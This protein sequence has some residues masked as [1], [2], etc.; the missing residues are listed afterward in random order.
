MKKRWILF[1]V[2]ITLCLS[3]IFPVYGENDDQLEQ[4]IIDSC[5]YNESADLTAYQLTAPQLKEI[6]FRLQNSGQLP[7]YVSD[8]YSYE[9]TS[10]GRITTFTPVQ[11]DKTKY[12]YALYEQTAT[13]IIHKTVFEGMS[14]WQIA[15]SIHDYLIANSAYDESLVLGEGYDL[16]VNGTSVC[17]GYAEA[18][19]DLMNRCG[20]PTIMV[21]STP[22]NHCWNLVCIGDQWYH[23]DVTWNDPTSN[24]HGRVEHTYFLLT[25]E[26][27]RSGE[28]P[29]YDWVTDIT[30][31]D[32][33]YANAFW[34][35]IDS[36]ICY[37]DSDTSYLLR[38]KDYTNYIYR[39]NEN[40][41]EETLLYTD[42]KSALD[43]GQGSYYF[44]HYGLSLRNEKLYF[45]STTTCY[46]M[47][48]DGSGV[49]ALYAY[50]AAGNGRH[51]YGISLGKD[52]LLLTLRNHDNSFIHESVPVALDAEHEHT[53]TSQVIAPTY[54]TSGITVHTCSCGFSYTSNPTKQL[55][56]TYEEDVIA[57][58]TNDSHAHF[59]PI[60]WIMA[61][62]YRLYA[63]IAIGFWLVTRIFRGLFKKK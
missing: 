46:S 6:F 55:E 31:T 15:L 7:W 56:H 36:Q 61:E 52:S 43:I 17:N 50:D 5:T 8:G 12:D 22:M 35:N 57:D 27:I 16:M 26:E 45:S 58:S 19:M 3:L 29:H 11:M 1:P 13:E 33:K 28:K 14:Q 42:E 21:S 32:T 23:V 30:C 10:D 2:I 49:T 63:A 62:S 24:V 47:N 34:K 39:R 38:T 25:D 20:I 54:T 18:Y 60:E 59:D 51:I 9:Y 37:A 44:P 48:L 40:T 4:T 41:G 53:F